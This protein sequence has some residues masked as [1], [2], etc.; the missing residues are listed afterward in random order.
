MKNVKKILC[1]LLIVVMCVVATPLDGL[2]GLEWPEIDWGVK[3]SA[4]S[5][6]GSCGD[7]VTYTF[8]SSTGKLVISGTGE[9]KNAFFTIIMTL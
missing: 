2:V 9:I 5:S 1:T 8:D 3:A 4:L 7:N 6:S